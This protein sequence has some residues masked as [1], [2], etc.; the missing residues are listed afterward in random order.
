MQ[1]DRT[2]E[3]RI[4]P[5][6]LA[7]VGMGCRFPGDA[8]DT[9]S[10]WRLLT[11][12][13][14]AIQEVPPERW[15]LQ[16]F[17][18]AN[19]RVPGAMVS[20]WGGFV[21]NL[22]R[23]DAR[24]WG[25]SP[26]EAVRMDPQQRW[27]LE[28]AW[29]ALEDSG[30]PPGEMRGASVGVFV[31][32]SSND[33]A[34]LQ[35]TDFTRMDMHTMS[36][37][38][39]SIAANRVSYMLDLRGPSLAIDTACSSALV[40]VWAACRSIWSG[41]CT[42]ALAG[43]VN[44]LIV[45]DSS[46]GFSKASMLS[47]SGQCYAFDSRADGYVRGEGAG[48]VYIKPLSD[49]MR[50]GD[51]I[52]ALIRSA[53]TN[54]DGHTTS[55][56]VPGIRGQSE[57]LAEAYELAGIPPQQVVY[58][59]A[60]GTGTP[61]GDPIEAAAL[62]AV[63][64]A[65]RSKDA[66]CLVG[67]IKSNIGHLEAGSGIAG[68]IKAALILHYNTIPPNANFQRA[69]PQIPFDALGLRVTTGLRE[70]PR[71]GGGRPVVGVNSFGFG[72]ANAHVVLE[73]APQQPTSTA[74][75]SAIQRPP[76][77]TISG[78]DAEALRAYV[79]SYAQLLA[80][81]AI[82][83]DD[84][85]F[86]AGVRKEH[87]AH[88]LVAT[89]KD[90]SQI[91]ERLA[92]WLG[93]SVR[94][95]GVVTGR[96]ASNSRKPVF[97]Y[98]GQGGQWWGMG[99]QLME[100][101]P[102]VRRA[103]DEI[104]ALLRPLT[105]WSLFEEMNRT[106]TESRIDETDVAQPAIFALQVALTELWRARGIQ[107]VAVV[108]HSVGEVAATYVAGIYSL[109]DAVR[110]IFERSRLQHTTRGK[111]RMLAVGITPAD[112]SNAIG[113]DKDR[114]H[115]AAVNSPH[116][117]T[118]AGDAEPLDRIANEL[119]QAGKFHRYLRVSYAFHS[120][121]MDT[122]REELLA[123]LANIYPSPEQIPFVSTVTGGPLSGLELDAS[124]WW[125]NV[126]EP[127]QF[128]AA[129]DH[130]RDLEAEA[131]LELGPH[132]SLTSA[133]S[134]C[135]GER[136]RT[137]TAF[138]SLRRGADDLQEMAINLAQLHVIGA[139]VDW[140]SFHQ[141]PRAFVRLPRYPWQREAFWLE[142]PQ[143]RRWRLSPASHPLLGE[144]IDAPLPT[145]R[146]QLHLAQFPYL[147]DHRFWDS[148][149]FPAAGYAE[150]GIALAHFLL[151][152][153]SHVV[154]NLSIEKVLFL[155]EDHSSTV[156]IVFE[157]EEK[158]F[159]IYS[160]Q[161]Q[162][163][164][165]W[166][167]HA[168]GRLTRLP[169]GAVDPIDL[170]NLQT[171]LPNHVAHDAYYGEMTSSGYQFGPNFSQL[172]NVWYGCG[173]ALAEI[174]VPA[175]LLETSGEYHL[176][177]AVLDACFHVFRALAPTRTQGLLLPESIR[178][179]NLVEHGTPCRLWAHGRL[180][181]SDRR[182][183]E[184]DISVHDDQGRRIAQI[185]GLRLNSV[186]QTGAESHVDR[187][188]FQFS[189]ELS[190][191]PC[192]A[193]VQPCRFPPAAE[194]SAAARES[195]ASA[196]HERGMPHYYEQLTPRI[197]ALAAQSVQNAWLQLGWQPQRGDRF[198]S[199][200][201][202]NRL[203]IAAPFDRLVLSH[204]G[205]LSRH[206]IVRQ[207]DSDSW[208]IDRVPEYVEIENR[209]EELAA[210]DPRFA[211]EIALHQRTS[212]KL[213][214]FLTEA[215]N[216]LEALFP[217]GSLALVE[218]LYT[219]SGD[220]P[221]HGLLLRNVL[222]RIEQALPPG[223]PLRVLEIGGGTGA[224]T[225]RILP[226]LPADRTH[227]VFTD[228]GP[229][230]LAAARHKFAQYPFVE[231]QIFDIDKP[232]GE[233]GIEPGSFDLLL[234]SLVVHVA[235]D[236]KR[237]LSNLRACLSPGGML[238]FLEFL[239]FRPS[240][241]NIFGLLPG[242]W[243][244]VDTDL[245]PQ[246]P[247]LERDAWLSL[248]A[249]CGFVD[250]GSFDASH[251]DHESALVFLFGSVVSPAPGES[252][253]SD[254]HQRAGAYLILAD[255][256][257]IADA[258][259][260][261]LTLHGHRTIDVRA[262]E[263]FA[264]INS[265][266][267]VVSPGSRSDLAR[268]LDRL[269]GSCESLAG[270]IHCWSLD[271]PGA[272]DGD[273]ES[274]SSAQQL[275]ALSVLPLLQ[276]FADAPGT[277][278]WFITRDVHAVVDGDQA[279][280]IFSAPITGLLRVA[281]NEFFPSRFNQTDIDTPAVDG[282]TVR[283]LYQEITGGDGEQEVALR[284]GSRYVLRL[285]RS[286]VDQLP[287]RTMLAVGPQR[288]SAAYRLETSRPGSLSNL[289]WNETRRRDPAMGEVEVRV[290][291]GGIN[292]RDVM[293]ALGMYPGNPR[294][295]SW[296]GDDVAGTI[297]RIGGNVDH[298][299]PGDMV[300]GM[301][302]YGFQS[303]VTMD[304]RMVF[305][306]PAHLSCEEA[307]TFPTAFL[308]AHYALVHLAR[309]RPG[310]KI[311]IHAGAG[312]VGQAAIQIAR[313]LKLEIFA[314]A[315]TDEKR[316]LLLELGAH[317]VMNSRTLE[318]ADEV[319]RITNGRGVDAVLNSLAGDFIH[320]SLSVLGP[321][322]RFLEIGKV[323]IYRNSPIE[324]GFLKQNVSYF[325][326]DL[327]QL[328]EFKPDLALTLMQEVNARIEA[329]DYRPL[330]RTIFPITEVEQAFRYMAQ[331]KHVGKVVLSFDVPALAIGPCTDAETRFRREG[332]YLITGGA[333][334]FGLELAKWISSHGARHI[335]LMSR[336]GPRDDAAERDIEALRSSGINVMD[337]RGDV[338]NPTDVRRCFEQIQ[339]TAQPLKGIVHAA[340]VLDDVFITELD[341]A[342]FAAAM[343]PKAAGAWNLHV[344]A[345]G[346]PI[347][348][349]ICLSSISSVVGNIRQANYNA[350]NCFLD[351][352]AHYRQARGLPALTIN[353]GPLL[354]A[355]FVERNLKTAELWAKIAEAFTLPQALDI[356]S[357]LTPRNPVQVAAVQADWGNLAQVY[358][359]VRRSPTFTELLRD[360][361]HAITGDSLLARLEHIEPA[362]WAD[363][364]EDL[365][366]T[367][368]SGVMGVQPKEIDRDGSLTQM[369]LDSLMALDLTNRMERAS[370]LRL[371]MSALLGKPSVR[372]LSQMILDR[373]TRTDM[374]RQAPGGFSN[375]T[376]S[377][378]EPLG[379]VLTHASTTNASPTGDVLRVL[380]PNEASRALVRLTFDA[381]ALLYVPDRVSAAGGFSDEQIRLLFGQE[382]FISHH[383][384]LKQGTIGVITL[385]LRSHE[386]FNSP[387]LPE[388]T[389]QAIALAQRHG[390][391]CV[392]LAGLIPSATR[393]GQDVRDWV[394]VSAPIVT[395]GHAT[396]TATVILNLQ[397]LLARIGRRLEQETLAVLGLGSIG[398]S[399]LDLALHVLPHPRSLILCDV[400]GK[401]TDLAAL[402]RRAR[403]EYGFRGQLDLLVSDVGVPVELYQAT[404]ILAAVSV[405]NAIDVGLLRPGTVI[406]D[407][408]FPPAFPLE[409]AISRLE[410]KG[411]VLFTNAGM[412]RLADPVQERVF[413]PPASDVEVA[414]YGMD[415][416]RAEFLRDPHEL[417]ACFLSSLLTQ[418]DESFPATLGSPTT[419]DLSAHY[420]GV[421]R[422]GI[423][424][425]R[426]QCG[427][428]FVPDEAIEAFR[429]RFGGIRS[430]S[431]QMA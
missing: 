311:L 29:E 51:R 276:V 112:A 69:N 328:W 54:Q 256:G 429:A 313:H 409:Q 159:R 139:D 282:R 368:V 299:R 330:T 292:F 236:V 308:T 260:E 220:F 187:S 193:E 226:A 348:H 421:I 188:L 166:E 201:L 160:S 42:S 158:I 278:F 149:V 62:G 124:Y 4:P 180:I 352:L 420:H 264:E 133:I 200:Q 425:A 423:Q 84:L 44:A 195:L 30:T 358:P 320:K 346:L 142:S 150:I 89:G 176:H 305:R 343:A 366:A 93:E 168:R 156:Q 192:S 353:M 73:Q 63:L 370:G 153:E 397:N 237:A 157:P 374:N 342:R 211:S 87:H 196:F 13:R 38:A 337:L 177:P 364:I 173:E 369:G 10:L 324:L 128:A 64:G 40:A 272:T 137:G 371:P 45:P 395:T 252:D 356:L 136:G 377:D 77:L 325:A 170:G 393:Y 399:C 415:A 57:L 338:A 141:H 241:E 97:V 336:T 204:L 406:V 411:D 349:F 83:L 315:G 5:F 355:G 23:F 145:W 347:E 419:E 120:H 202:M 100:R 284:G 428:Y 8:N 249:D 268:V 389:R 72:G 109:S 19:A 247:L 296:F 217:G 115:I 246:S 229:S 15:N 198:T 172:A 140:A 297:E 123:S 66:P 132:P 392:S 122:L 186:E 303:Y 254:G 39:S 56:T 208:E 121:Q 34:R 163:D 207:C 3:E 85:C 341:D 334:G 223:R 231:F 273:L 413:L 431:E 327:S 86:M 418:T 362:A 422:L 285:R 385:P 309:M 214:A 9:E 179:I 21:S 373:L 197:E 271:S 199:R 101:E 407:D 212:P 424:A 27:L 161:S 205:N 262:G 357:E 286:Q 367:Q 18:R 375:R 126:R 335:A 6:P 2:A 71:P 106:D 110:V 116:L 78:G 43:G 319:M 26:R 20:K 154:E 298:L 14:S 22:D 16:R 102:I 114:V 288:I 55:M 184:A 65:G 384:E 379:D 326:I 430:A 94:V 111:G 257:G 12:G 312:G 310:E 314:T 58:V 129:I 250:C 340:M 317:H 239:P 113:S 405:P 287:A 401:Q 354:G 245:R 394:G 293:K 290:Q 25:V 134:D 162:G 155:K 400:F 48:V 59:E 75:E 351:A 258:L 289:T 49:A 302:P 386:L 74:L 209:W 323:D 350:G 243:R 218:D 345:A 171:S 329:G 235:E 240:Y 331:A 361:A 52:Y 151:P 426:A 119:G 99:R 387:R 266:E 390:A 98:S 277:S 412:A 165:E 219:E 76:L 332:T 118:L 402:A 259:D 1:C 427:R 242:W 233:Q 215:A 127:V 32:I 269:D 261:Q 225:Q 360:N 60:H 164:E 365:V 28:T 41:N 294:D 96:A 372:S 67:S 61:V 31:G 414:R 234:G 148:P 181:Q 144:Q 90:A 17:Y 183:M 359:N 92:A 105:G 224:F 203:G 333:G 281:N 88:R 104:D 228:V 210:A 283:S 11:T 107:P 191:L 253:R 316:Q 125:R 131:F 248:L 255:R 322:G 263:C 37:C 398:K 230:M 339:T 80:D 206:G 47:P 301:V 79:E 306:I 381:A 185:L 275:G 33:Y 152:D 117:V 391:K 244:F 24:F 216:P 380:S 300:H 417:T 103:I 182:S 410:S 190:S 304:A 388:L 270:V 95:D 35:M 227:Y 213:S 138:H 108:G 238:L 321:Y 363:V 344:A 135:L 147:N 408:S 251:E 404:T 70:L 378:Q 279:A 7:I 295:L 221:L 376:E 68:L 36:G 81:E 167:L 280:G 143:S 232:P 396:T 382:P 416:F 222:K 265:T 178:R 130:L 46:V 175:Q 267:F 403:E 194:I 174:V 274:L 318:F 82:C 91:R 291:S 189:W 307:A 146:F 383:Y 53:A 169:H 50:D